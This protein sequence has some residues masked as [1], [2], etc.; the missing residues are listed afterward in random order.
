MCPTCLFI[1]C[2]NRSYY[3]ADYNVGAEVPVVIMHVSKRTEN[4]QLV[5]KSRINIEFYV[6]GSVDLGITVDKINSKKHGTRKPRNYIGTYIL[7]I[8]HAICAR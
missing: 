7:R 8:L 3:T 6:P 5:A 2:F 4:Y 1:I